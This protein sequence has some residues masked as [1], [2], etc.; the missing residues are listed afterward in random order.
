MTDEQPPIGPASEIK[1]AE[2]VKQESIDSETE[3]ALIE[4]GRAG[5]PVKEGSV[6]GSFK[7]PGA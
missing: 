1:A 3:V 6:L 2:M 7:G 4:A 5:A